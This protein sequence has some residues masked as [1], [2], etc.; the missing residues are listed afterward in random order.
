MPHSHSDMLTSGVQI[1][2]D[3]MR[4]HTEYACA[5]RVHVQDIPVL[6]S[7][8]CSRIVIAVMLAH[9]YREWLGLP[10]S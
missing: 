5:A 4:C 1:L 6:L 10:A 9:G 7:C 2:S 3:S 8:F